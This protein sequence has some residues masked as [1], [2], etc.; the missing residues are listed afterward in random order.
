ML[1]LFS[2]SH[3]LS[4]V[5]VAVMKSRE[6]KIKIY[7]APSLLT[8]SPP[9]ICTCCCD[10]I[11]EIKTKIYHASSL[12]TLSPPLICTC[13][14]DEIKSRSRFIML[15]LFSLSHLFHLNNTPQHYAAR[16]SQMI[17]PKSRFDICLNL[18][19]S[20]LKPA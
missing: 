4:F 2:L 6:F 11:K 17:Y 10:E 5:L 12:L 7:H 16:N 13:C 3:L 15:L 14:C 18:S 8:L 9:L 20:A 1:L 19:P